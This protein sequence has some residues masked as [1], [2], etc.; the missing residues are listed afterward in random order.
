MTAIVRVDRG[1]II[2]CWN[3]AAEQI[4]GFTEL[5]AVGSSLD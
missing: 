5:E 2:D 3:V 1:G 4:F